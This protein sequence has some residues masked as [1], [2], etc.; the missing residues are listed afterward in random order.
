MCENLVIKEQNKYKINTVTSVF[1]ESEK[2]R[3]REFEKCSGKQENEL[4]NGD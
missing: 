1:G 3:G 2:G 4:G